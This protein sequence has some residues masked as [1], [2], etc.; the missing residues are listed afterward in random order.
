MIRPVV[1]S[2]LRNTAFFLFTCIKQNITTLG[3]TTCIPV[4]EIRWKQFIGKVIVLFNQIEMYVVI[5]KN[6]II[7]IFIVTDLI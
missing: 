6:F 2:A 7:S 5:L 3:T 4:I 1:Y